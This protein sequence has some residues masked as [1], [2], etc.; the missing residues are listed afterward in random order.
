MKQMKDLNWIINKCKFFKNN[1]WTAPNIKD[2]E[3]FANSYQVKAKSC[4][5]DRVL[6]MHVSDV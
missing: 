5:F 1:I 6:N 4:M 3:F 2:E